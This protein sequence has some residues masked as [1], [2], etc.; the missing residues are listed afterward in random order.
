[1][2]K[3]IILS[4]DSIVELYVYYLHPK[5]VEVGNGKLTYEENKSHFTLE[6]IEKTKLYAPLPNIFI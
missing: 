6:P 2:D 4:G 3:K 5:R 1:M